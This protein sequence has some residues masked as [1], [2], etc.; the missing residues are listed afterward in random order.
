MVVWID[1][2]EQAGP[3]LTTR[4]YKLISYT[5]DMSH[6]QTLKAIYTALI[7]SEEALIFNDVICNG[8]H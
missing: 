3:T 7:F 2:Q 5:T 6:K 1:N 8:T 4:I